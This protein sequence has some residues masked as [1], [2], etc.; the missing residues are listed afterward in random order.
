[1]KARGINLS[2]EQLEILPW[3]ETRLF[4][5][6]PQPQCARALGLYFLYKE[7]PDIVKK[8]KHFSDEL[9]NRTLN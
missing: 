9:E 8:Y 3:S 4:A 1:M 5:C 2:N 6:L 7:R